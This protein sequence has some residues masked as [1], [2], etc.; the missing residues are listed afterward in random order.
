MLR[1]DEDK[2]IVEF[3]RWRG[4]EL[5]LTMQ[6]GLNKRNLTGTTQAT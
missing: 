6:G 1:F 3:Y 2:H 5:S 4:K